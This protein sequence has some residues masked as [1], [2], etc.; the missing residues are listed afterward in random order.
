MDWPSLP[1]WLIDSRPPC[2][3]PLLCCLECRTFLILFELH[4]LNFDLS[5]SFFNP[6]FSL[7]F[8]CHSMKVFFKKEQLQSK[9]LSESWSW[10]VARA[11]VDSA[12]P[13]VTLGMEA[14]FSFL[15]PSIHMVHSGPQLEP[16]LLGLG[17]MSRSHQTSGVATVTAT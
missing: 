9:T 7:G 16:L 4:R 14:V 1:S 3:L 11:E 12:L 17:F 15:L 6:S 13:C 10:S 8:G 2:L 5:T